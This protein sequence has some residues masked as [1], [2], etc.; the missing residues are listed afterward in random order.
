M[1]DHI[2][3]DRNNKYSLHNSSNKNGEYLEEFYLE[4]RLA[5]LSTKFQKR[6]GKLWTYPQPN[7]VKA[8]LDY[9]FTNKKWMNST[10]KWEAYYSFEEVSSNHRSAKIRLS[11]RR[12]KTQLKLYDLTGP[13]SPTVIIEINIGICKKQV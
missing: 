6:E 1:N 7:Y 9:I 12:N 2:G 11:L 4:N 3:K 13:H 8:Q 5:C 10:L